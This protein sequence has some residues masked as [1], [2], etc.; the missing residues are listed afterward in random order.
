M[1][2]PVIV[3]ALA[4]L[5]IIFVPLIARAQSAPPEKRIALV[6]GNDAY[7]TLPR[8]GNASADARDIGEALKQTGF[9]VTVG[10][11]VKRR[12][13]YQLIDAFAA[14][15][16]ASPDT[17]GLFYYAGHGVQANGRNYLV[18]VDADLESD[19]DLEP[20]AVDAG[21]VLRA[22]DHARNRMNIVILDACRDNPLPKGRSLS[23]GLASMQAPRGTFIGYAAAPGQSARDGPPGQNGVFTGVLLKELAEPG[24][25]LE[26]VFKRVISGVAERTGGEQLPWMESSVQ[27]DFYFR[28]ATT[29]G[30][31]SPSSNPPPA[32]GINSAGAD[33]EIVFWQS[34]GRDAP[35]DDYEEYLRQY[36]QGHFVGLARSRLAALRKPPAQAEPSG[37]PSAPPSNP[38]EEV[39]IAPAPPPCGGNTDE[40]LT[41]TISA[42]YE[43]IRRMDIGAYAALWTPGGQYIR[44]DTGKSITSEQKIAQRRGDFARWRSAE[45]N[46]EQVRVIDKTPSTASVA[47]VYSMSVE[48]P[49][50]RTSRDLHVNERYDLTCAP[51]GQWLIRRNA[52]FVGR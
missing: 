31:A 28:P 51:S 11:D 17:V 6:I 46:M 45:I 15:I 3:A 14:K 7:Q 43:A 20:E 2:K 37:P 8:L 34:I 40:R 44:A 23:R 16:S 36:P 38:K 42:L 25:Q 13:L 35:A 18:P 47:V 33:A 48:L 27:G 30:I 10:T 32:P 52:D 26:N 5:L 29:V 21:K 49:N 1:P 50:G 41:A 19:A 22:M 39:R 12:E 9:E 24:L 4:F